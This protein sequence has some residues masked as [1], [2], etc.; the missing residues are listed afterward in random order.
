MSRGGAAGDLA[1]AQYPKAKDI[2]QRIAGIR[3]VEIGLAANRWDP[4]TVSVVGNARDDARKKVTVGGICERT[5]TQRIQT[6][7]RPCTHRKDVANDAAHPRGGSLKGFN[8]AGMVV[9]FHFESHRP[10]IADIDHPGIFLSGPH[11]HPIATGGKFPQ[12]ELR[13]LVGT[14]LAP[15]DRKTP[16]SV[17]FGSRPRIPQIRSYSSGVRPCLAITSGVMSGSGIF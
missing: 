2:H 14:M 7:D 17:K 10:I 11:Q 15:H 13:I 1:V 3:F 5:E 12:F 4:D 9:T 16:S 8:G 6:K